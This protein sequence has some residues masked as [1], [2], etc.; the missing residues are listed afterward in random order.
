MAEIRTRT[1]PDRI[2]TAGTAG[3]AGTALMVAGMA[4]IS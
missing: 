3:T 1:R 4:V 2:V